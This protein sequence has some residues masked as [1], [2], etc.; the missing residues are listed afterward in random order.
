MSG[1]RLFHP[2]QLVSSISPEVFSFFPTLLAVPTIKIRARSVRSIEQGSAETGRG[3][4]AVTYNWNAKEKD[5]NQHLV[6]SLLK[7]Q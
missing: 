2:S 5:L 1:V 6:L 4:D 3:L 7:K